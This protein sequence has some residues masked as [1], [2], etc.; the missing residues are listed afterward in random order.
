LAAATIVLTLAM[1]ASGWWRVGARYDGWRV[2]FVCGVISVA[3]YHSP[4]QWVAKREFTLNRVPPVRWRLRMFF[5][6]SE[7]FDWN[8]GIL[9]YQH[10]NGFGVVAHTVKFIA[11]PAAAWI[12]LAAGV[13]AWRG[14][15]ATANTCPHCGYSQDGL[16][17][18]A[19]CPECGNPTKSHTAT[20]ADERPTQHMP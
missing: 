9:A 8:L 14:R 17:A 7:G 15:G 16:P 11:W 3:K 19:A 13:L 12:A 5:G 4:Q 6:A 1:I 2:E 18:D 20:H 10:L